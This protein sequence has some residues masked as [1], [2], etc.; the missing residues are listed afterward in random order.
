M[1]NRNLKNRI[2]KYIPKAIKDK[3]SV[4]KNIYKENKRSLFV[5]GIK[6]GILIPLLISFVIYTYNI[7]NFI[8]S[9]NFEKTQ[10]ELC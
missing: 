4:V 10:K 3:I 1:T 2:Y 8:S 6:I 5:V 7:N 9:L